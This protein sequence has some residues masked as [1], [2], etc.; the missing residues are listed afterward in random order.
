MWVYTQADIIHTNCVS[1]Q[2][3]AAYCTSKETETANPLT[4]EIACNTTAYSMFFDAERG[5]TDRCEGDLSHN[6]EVSDI[7]PPLDHVS[8]AD[9]A[10]QD[11]V[12]MQCTDELNKV[13]V[14]PYSMFSK[15]VLASVDLNSLD[16]STLFN[17][18]LFANRSVAFYGNVSYSYG[19]VTHTPTP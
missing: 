17:T 19:G 3:I 12:I 9:T 13:M 1:T 7:T 15:H 18:C 11:T 4:S 5:N 14:Q 8:S 10:T 16:N 2:T 6:I